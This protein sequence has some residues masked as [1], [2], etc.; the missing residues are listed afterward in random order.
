MFKSVQIFKI[1]LLSCLLV[2]CAGASY[3]PERLVEHENDPLEPVNRTVLS[4]NDVMDT[5]VLHPVAQGYR[6]IVPEF[7]RRSVSNFFATLNQPAYFMN[8]LLQGQ[9]KD[10][11]SILG[12]TSVNLT[13]G[14][15]G[16]F[17]VATEAGIPN[18][19]NDFGQTLAKWGWHDGGPFLMLPFLGP[20]NV[21]DAIGTG[22]DMA[23][24]PVYWRLRHSDEDVLLYGLYALNGLQ[25]REGVLDL[26]DNL[27]A[28]STDYYASMRTMYQQNRRKK[29]NQV[30]PKL[31]DETPDYEFEIEIEDEE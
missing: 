30:V 22:V 24:D 18:P 23:A 26:T 1:A 28:S 13:F 17:D 10:A 6:F 16:L 29:I 3:S 9:M 21:R 4:F 20:S 25:K 11:A 12:R 19:E 31:A 15:F 14:F 8:A 27:K 2:G 5:Y 7:I